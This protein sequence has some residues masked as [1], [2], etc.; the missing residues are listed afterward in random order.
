MARIPSFVRGV[1]MG[2][3]EEYARRAG[4]TRITPELMERVRRE[5]PVDFSKRIPFFLRDRSGVHGG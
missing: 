5:M 4:E 2:R 3:V 1:V